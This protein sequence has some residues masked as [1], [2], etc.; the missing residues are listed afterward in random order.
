MFE[1]SC[2]ALVTP[3]KSTGEIDENALNSLVEWHIQEGTDAIVVCGT[4]GES[5]T[6]TPHEHH[7]V[8]HLV[9]K[10]ANK[11]IPIIAGTGT[12]ATASTIEQTLAAKEI[13]VDACL[14]VTPYY[15][16]PT[17]EG[18]IAHY[19]A[20]AKAVNIPIILYNVPTRTACDMQPATVG[21][22]SKV[23]T[24]IGIKEA[25]GNIPRLAELREK[26]RKD[27]KF[28]SGDDPTCLEFIT[29]GGHGVISI[30]SN[31]VP[32]AM[33]EMCHYALKKEYDK[34]QALDERLQALHHMMIAQ[35]NPMP[36]KWAMHYMG[37]VESGIRLPLTALTKE[38][39]ENMIQALNKAN[40]EIRG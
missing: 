35:P 30:T 28:Y 21:E 7:H 39:H 38:H 4:T 25:T 18:L 3:M 13:G 23:P 8:I 12:N 24:I 2:V 9:N 37:K 34:A 22:L 5:S 29:K 16:R 26:C 31:A 19:H 32:K 14:I 27:F 6:L 15:N 1:G 17:Q 40:I 20:I 36:V 33:H 11:R 10:A